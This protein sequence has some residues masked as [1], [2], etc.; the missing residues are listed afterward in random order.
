MR[1]DGAKCL[2]LGGGGFIGTNLCVGLA[3]AGASVEAFGRRPLFDFPAADIPW[4]E[5]EFRDAGRLAEAVEGKDY[6][7]H[8]LGG[9]VPA[10]S[11]SDPAGDVEASLLP[12]LQLMSICR[13][14]GVKRIIFASSGGTVYGITD[15]RPISETSPTEPITAYGVNK[16]A[17]E[18]YL[19]L[20]RRLY[21]LDSVVLRISNPYG[22]Y[23][24]AR[25]PQGIV[26]TLLTRALA[27]E[28]IEVWGDGSV[29]RDFLHV[30]DVVSA[31]LVAASYTGPERLFN[32]GSGQGRS[33]RDVAESIRTALH[34]NSNRVRYR[35][36]RVTDVP[37]NILD[38]DLIAR[39]IG[40]TPQIEWEAGLAATVTWMK[41]LPHGH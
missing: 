24:Y 31:M 32:V 14:A 3:T 2:V 41:Y 33:M 40:W 13:A 22:P 12:S 36:G 21:G 7:F 9:S 26:G 30:D 20:Y 15:A 10:Q 37:A 17:V 35:P 18:K 27:G 8:L 5:A 39:T 38:I 16:L 11:N 19:S 6:V 1:L 29:I 23:Q 34:L 25:R 28:T 4:H